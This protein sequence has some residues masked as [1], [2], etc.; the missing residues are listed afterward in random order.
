MNEGR[1]PAATFDDEQSHIIRRPRLERLLD[2]S[3]A[4]VILLVA[5]A[6]YGKTT[7]AR[8]WLGS[9]TRRSCWCRADASSADVRALAAQLVRSITSAMPGEGERLAADL[10]LLSEASDAAVTQRLV[11]AC[12]K[13]SRDLWLAIDDYQHIAANADAEALIET[14]T[15]ETPIN[16]LITSRRRPA[17]ATSRRRLYG[18]MLELSQAHLA[19]TESEAALVAPGRAGRFSEIYTLAAGWPAVIALA[20]LTS[21]RDIPENAVSEQL[22][23]F[24][25]QEL[26]ESAPEELRERLL[27][28]SLP[29][30]L[31]P[32]TVAFLF[33]EVSAETLAAAR[34]SGFLF[35]GL[36]GTPE[37]HPLVRRFLLQQA[38]ERSDLSDAGLRLGRFLIG[39]RRWDEAFQVAR[40]ARSP[41][42]MEDVLEAA[43]ESM[44]DEGR[45][46]T[47]E[48]WLEDARTLGVAEINLALP[49][50]RLAL[51]RGRFTE[52][53]ALALHTLEHPS[54]TRSVAAAALLI[55]GHAAH[56]SDREE[57]AAS[58]FERAAAEADSPRQR[59]EAMRGRFLAAVVT[60]A[61][62]AEEA[63]AAY[64]DIEDATP[65]NVLRLAAA[66]TNLAIVRGSI[67]GCIRDLHAASEL[68]PHC[69]DPMTTSAFHFHL[70]YT[71]TLHASYEEAG[72]SA[73][74]G[75][76]EAQER[77][78]DFAVPHAYL[79]LAMAQTGQRRFDLAQ[80]SLNS[81]NS[82]P[83]AEQDLFL[84]A[85]VEAAQSRLLLAQ[86][87]PAE[88]LERVA[89]E[90]PSRT[91][92]GIRGE[93]LACR[94]LAAAALGDVAA[95]RLATEQATGLTAAVECMT[96]LACASV[97]MASREKPDDAA[98][99]ARDAFA[100]AV[101]TDA[102]D[103]FVLLYRMAPN[104][105]FAPAADAQTRPALVHLLNRVGDGALAESLGIGKPDG[106]APDWGL[107]KRE[108]EVY[109]LLV[110]GM[111]NREIAKALFIS[112]VTVK[113]HVRH[114]Y[115]KLGVHSRAQAIVAGVTRR[116]IKP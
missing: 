66:R 81:A 27:A 65:C 39:R 59:K 52:A 56:M 116:S 46:T 50:A 20:A 109:D 93:R 105:L 60:E 3:D 96:L 5:P 15:Q 115:E 79:A 23:D 28:L 30:V 12:E 14:L 82:H 78:I 83:V 113:V 54:R 102:Y 86:G 61:E 21:M 26:Y 11:A 37:M 31:S 111:S 1:D 8:Q 110:A 55:A 33:G 18:D 49:A 41:R 43:A 103:A 36:D 104:V 57:D 92:R 45:P 75:L 72:T 17:W 101:A 2:E 94:A 69:G 68:L 51:R 7:L 16:L 87:Q 107:S 13:W 84:R 62:Q 64:A 29:P 9:P 90:L 70:S 67:R 80:D 112:E 74:R 42:L 22:H 35:A 88:A 71:L 24:L 89:A 63:F 85:N 25:L 10:A 91:L 98:S 106:A 32:D 73:Q 4:R 114:I 97:L 95:A 77:G 19:M 53:E 48:R 99:L 44:M 76:D 47:V 38:Y 58:Y 40:N 108:Q 34:V 100:V 6:G